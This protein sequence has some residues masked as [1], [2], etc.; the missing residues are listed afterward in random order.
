MMALSFAVPNTLL[1]GSQ[2]LA[3]PREASAET[4]TPASTEE[5][6]Q[7]F[8][9]QGPASKAM[10]IAGDRWVELHGYVSQLLEHQ[11]A[12]PTLPALLAK[13]EV[14]KKYPSWLEHLLQISRLRGYFTVYPGRKTVNV[15]LGVHN[16][17]SDAPE[18]YEDEV[19]DSGSRSK[20]DVMS[21][22]NEGAF[23]PKPLVDVVDTLPQRGT[24][25]FLQNLPLLSWDGRVTTGAELSR[26]ALEYAQKFRQEVGGCK[27]SVGNPPLPDKHARDLFCDGR[28]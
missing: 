8:L 9:W 16:D 6:D 24:L 26:E 1:D 21:D 4:V 28:S 7:P 14:S 19:A 2:P 23:N 12:S 10:V 15:L 27:S 5:N 17:L 25:P 22:G 3:P 18:E 13:K 11:G 20:Q